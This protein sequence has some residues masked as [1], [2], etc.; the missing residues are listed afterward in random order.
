VIIRPNKAAAVEL[1]RKLGASIEAE[2]RTGI[3]VSD[4]LQPRK[5]YWAKTMPLPP[6]EAEIGY[7][8]AGKA[9]HFFLVQALTGVSDTQEASLV[10]L[11]TGV[12]YS[13]DLVAL[14][15]E[16][17][18]TRWGMLPTTLQA[19]TRATEGYIAQCRAYAAL[20]RTCEWNL[21]VFYLMA[22]DLKIDSKPPRLKVYTLL[23]EEEDLALERNTLA[24]KKHKLEAALDIHDPLELPLCS[25]FM[26]YRMVGHGRGRKKTI[27]GV[28]KWW[29][30]CK[31]EG[32]Y[33]DNEQ[34][35]IV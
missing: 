22:L 29:N 9:H 14:K 3:H 16:F 15:G 7:W 19:V 21:Y 4:L 20:M 32:R 28:C 31:P 5:A 11:A 1:Y 34:E 6:T 35:K 25:E 17:K 18:T 27:E 10:D 23:F 33:I 24:Y 26:C 2:Q 13:P 12:H 8:L 30:V